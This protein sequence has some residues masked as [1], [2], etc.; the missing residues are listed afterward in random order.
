[1][2]LAKYILPLTI[3]GSVALINL[4]KYAV[5]AILD[6]YAFIKATRET[7][8]LLGRLSHK[9]EARTV[10]RTAKGFSVKDFSLKK[11]PNAVLIRPRHVSWL[12][13]MFH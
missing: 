1:L 11:R 10:F 12:I 8:S 7:E 2:K 5:Y 4:N 9:A 6:I 3:I 13:N